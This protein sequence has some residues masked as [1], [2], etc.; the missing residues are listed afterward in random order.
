MSNMKSKKID[1][2]MDARMEVFKGVEKLANA[3]KTTLG[4][5]GR[6][7]ILQRN[8]GFQSTKDGV[9]VA[10]EINLKDP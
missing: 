3:V 6:N 8:E 1:F 2:G 4:P 9:T 5:S 7:V 10:K